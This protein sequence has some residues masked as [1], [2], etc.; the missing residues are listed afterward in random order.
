MTEKEIFKSESSKLTG[1]GVS[2]AAGDAGHEDHLRPEGANCDVGVSDSQHPG[3]QGA[4]AVPKV[5]AEADVCTAQVLAGIME[6]DGKSN[7][8]VLNE[9]LV[10]LVYVVDLG[11]GNGEGNLV[12][13]QRKRCGLMKKDGAKMQI[14][15]V[16]SHL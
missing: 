11:E 16:S 12:W 5:P 3:D 13:W 15:P 10:V 9:V 14:L 2:A 7:G 8:L 6:L 4:S 1:S